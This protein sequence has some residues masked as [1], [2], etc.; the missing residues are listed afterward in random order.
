MLAVRLRGSAVVR[1]LHLLP[2]SC[3]V[4][5]RSLT[6]VREQFDIAVQQGRL[7]QDP[8]QKEAADLADR[9]VG[10]IVRYAV[11]KR[12]A[13]ERALVD[14]AARA[15]LA[16]APAA[17][18]SGVVQ[19]EGARVTD[20]LPPS[21]T[22]TPVSSPVSAASAA[23]STSPL[24]ASR[25]AA[26]S[27]MVLP[28]AVTTEPTH[29]TTSATA[30]AVATAP[31][32]PPAAP[33]VRMP[34]GLYLWGP[35]GCGKTMIANMAF[36]ALSEHA[37]ALSALTQ[38]SAA[39]VQQP[40]ALSEH[41][42]AQFALLDA[43]A[44][45][46][47]A[48]PDTSALAAASGTTPA[49]SLRAA[50]AA[51]EASARPPLLPLRRMHFHSLLMELHSRLA[52]AR[53]AQPADDPASPS[54]RELLRAIAAEIA[55][56]EALVLLVDDLEMVDVA[57]A[58]LMELFFT[59]LA[60]SGSVLLVTSNWAPPELYRDGLQREYFQ[61]FI[62]MLEVRRRRRALAGR[63]CGLGRRGLAGGEQAARSTLGRRAGT[64]QAVLCRLGS[65][66]SSATR[67]QRGRV[68]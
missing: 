4:R 63:F 31:T 39:L 55:G 8:A 9:A 22:V 10:R 62:R 40:S 51:S 68:L 27:E 20:T 53:A 11:E 14:A 7:R 41:A 44:T 6:T 5:K 37:A 54:D 61:P 23:A 50:P 66:G 60:K 35:V 42:A 52:R 58:F 65:R 45:R 18:Q 16:S 38:D 57:D 2:G 3:F 29:L 1:S 46:T 24:P 32:Q 34:K 19:A 13:A 33:S 17:L 25:P 15:A 30:A 49:T 28:S 67:L 56:R 43:D 64:R 21:V 47:S 59:T 26:A 12:A 36:S 48:V